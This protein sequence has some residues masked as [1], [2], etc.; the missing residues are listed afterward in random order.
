MPGY[1]RVKGEFVLFY[2]GKRH[3]GAQPDG[4]SV[5]FRPRNPAHLA[6][7]DG[8]SAELNAGGCAQLRIEAIDAL[9]L[10]YSGSH[11]QRDL[12]VAARDLLTSLLGTTV[13][14]SGGEGLSVRTADPHPIPGYICT[15]SVDPYGRPVSFAFAGAVDGPDRKD[16]VWVTPAM[17]RKSLNYKLVRAGH[18]YPTFYTGLPVDLREVVLEAADD[19]WGDD[20]GMWPHDR[21]MKGVSIPS[22]E[23]LEA[24]AIWPKLYRRL[25]SYFGDQ[26]NT[27]GLG[28]FDQWIRSDPDRDDQLF[29][30][31]KGELA[32]LH[33]V[34]R[35]KG[36]RIG[37]KFWPE[38]LIIVP[39]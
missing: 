4:D 39:R 10:H 35:V 27:A 7:L 16:G 24:V 30:L 5:W 28:K 17:L 29:I 38:D 15:R 2:R 6:Q 1:R 33:D 20:A 13:T 14:Y 21:S 19:A 36:N 34:I 18:A 32:N 8:R 31:S 37:M 22:L 12:A 25:R 23:A 26:G 9:E 3:V 11:Q